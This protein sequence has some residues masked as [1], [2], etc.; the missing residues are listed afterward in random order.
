MRNTTILTSTC[1]GCIWTGYATKKMKKD[2]NRRSV[3]KPTA[4]THLSRSDSD[5]ASSSNTTSP[6]NDP[7][8]GNITI[9]ATQD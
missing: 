1:S 6:K 8:N 5:L 3:Q 7:N 9:T 4:T 2:Q